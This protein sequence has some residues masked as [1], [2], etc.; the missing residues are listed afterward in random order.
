[1]VRVLAAVELYGRRAS[2]L[3]AGYETYLL[4]KVHPAK[5]SGIS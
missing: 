3:K 5:N 1:M 4:L 2:I